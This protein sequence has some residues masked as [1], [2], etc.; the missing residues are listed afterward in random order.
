M[1]FKI[2]WARNKTFSQKL[3]FFAWAFVFVVV[4]SF[5]SYLVYGVFMPCR[6]NFEGGC[7]LGGMIDGVGA[8]I[9]APFSFWIG[10]GL[11][12]KAKDFFRLPQDST[13]I[14][15]ILVSLPM[16]FPVFLI[17]VVVRRY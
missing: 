4:N 6:N 8:C 3:G 17:F 10:W 15:R 16:P 14:G 9:V 13:L 11:M 1:A 5:F 7:G 2:V 12:T